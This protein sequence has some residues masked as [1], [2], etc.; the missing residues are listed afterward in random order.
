MNNR[1]PKALMEADKDM[2]K[3]GRGSYLVAVQGNMAI[4]KWYDNKPVLMLSTHDGAHPEHTV[5]RWSKQ[6]KKYLNVIQP[7]VVKSYNFKMGGVDMADRMLSFC[8]SRNRTKKWTI[9]VMLHLLD[10][11]V[12]NG[13]IQYKE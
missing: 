6:E 10:I 13:W 9:R 7:N 3:R 12:T 4:T 2:K 1:I 8:A 5:M 11:A